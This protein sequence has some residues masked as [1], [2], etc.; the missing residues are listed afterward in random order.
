MFNLVTLWNLEYKNKNEQIMSL[1]CKNE[2]EQIRDHLFPVLNKSTIIYLSSQESG[3]DYQN[4]TIKEE[5][6]PC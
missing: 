1:E 2:N 5:F 4:S 3:L 6:I